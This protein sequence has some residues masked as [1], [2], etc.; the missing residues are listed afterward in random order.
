[1]K[2]LIIA[3][4]LTSLIACVSQKEVLDSW[5]GSNTQQLQM[6]WGPASRI[7][8]DGNGGQILIFATQYYINGSSGYAGDDGI[9][10]GGS[11]GYTMW[12]YKFMY[13]DKDKKIYYYRTERLRVPPLQLDL[14][15]YLK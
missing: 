12:Y 3:F 7:A 8:D 15:I 10:R 4:V 11:Q 13:A 14:T 6:S 2:K 9:V 5:L 1:M